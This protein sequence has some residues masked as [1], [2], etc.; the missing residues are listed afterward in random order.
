M[1]KY[2]DKTAK[3]LAAVTMKMAVIGG[4]QASLI[5]SYQPVEPKALTRLL[6]EKS[7]K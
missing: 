6:A 1:R 7:K 5:G 2:A 3:T 4:N